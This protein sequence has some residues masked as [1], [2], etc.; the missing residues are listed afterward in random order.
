[1]SDFGIV[2]WRGGGWTT[3]ALRYLVLV[4]IVETLQIRLWETRMW[5]DALKWT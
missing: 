2:V 4:V 3:I 1:M 5:N